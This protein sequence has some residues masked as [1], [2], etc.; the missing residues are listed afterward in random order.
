MQCSDDEGKDWAL[1]V[2]GELAP[3]LVI[4]GDVVEHLKR[5]EGLDLVHRLVRGSK[6]VLVSVPIVHMPQGPD[7]LNHYGCHLYHWSL[8]EMRDCLDIRPAR[9][10]RG[11]LLVSYFSTSDTET[12]R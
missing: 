11:D 10:W 1:D 6:S 7:G 3:D 9:A 8:E 12:S 4:A 2:Y 5:D